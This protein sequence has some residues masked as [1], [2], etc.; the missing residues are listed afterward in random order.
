ME[1]LSHYFV[2]AMT[3]NYKTLH[4]RSG[5]LQVTRLPEN[6]MRRIKMHCALHDTT[7]RD[8][9]VQTLKAALDAAKTP[10]IKDNK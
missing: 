1:L 6:M 10:E 3:T 9:V 4:P 2:F 7:I 8:F 5:G